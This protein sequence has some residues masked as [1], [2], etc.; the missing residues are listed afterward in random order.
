MTITSYTKSQAFIKATGVRKAG[1]YLV[2][3]YLR[4][5]E[6]MSNGT[7]ILYPTDTTKFALKWVVAHKGVRETKESMK[8]QREQ[9]KESQAHQRIYLQSCASAYH[10]VQWQ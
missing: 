6:T 1:Q 5:M 9:Q 7:D 8:R 3:E 4:L 2:M 10:T